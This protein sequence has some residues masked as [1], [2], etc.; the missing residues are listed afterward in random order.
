LKD[1]N[2]EEEIAKKKKEAEDKQKKI[3]AERA[4]AKAANEAAARE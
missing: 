1:F 4:K 3:T 2:L